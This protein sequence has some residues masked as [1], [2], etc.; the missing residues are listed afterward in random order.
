M[1]W[2][3]Q[4]WQSIEAIYLSILKMPFIKELSNGTLP[5]NKFQFYMMQDSLYLEHFGRALALIGAKADD[6]I[7]ALTYMRFAENA[8]VVENA[9]HEFY[10]MDFGISDKGSIQ[11]VCHHYIH[12]LKSTAAFEVAEIAM[13]ATLPCFWFYK[14]VGDHII[15][16]HRSSD[17]PYQKWIQTYGGEDFALAVKNAVAI[18]DRVAE[19]ATASTRTR[20]TEAF[21]TAS[22]M[23]YKFWDA[24]YKL[25]TWESEL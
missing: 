24:A 7:D 5:Q 20:M 18:C 4:A 8:I 2:S 11:P 17:N 22:R 14:N 15:A 9:L 3:E 12:F 6:I 19:S 10:F 1:K 25:K 16:N 21:I 23:E 13:A